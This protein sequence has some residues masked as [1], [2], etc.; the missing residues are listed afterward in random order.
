LKQYEF[1]IDSYQAEWVFRAIR[2][3]ADVIAVLM[4]SLKV[5]MLPATPVVG[6][7]GSITLRVS[8][9]SRIFFSSETKIFSIGFPF[10]VTEVDGALTFRTIHHSDVG[11]RV[12][13]Q[14]LGILESTD[15]L[16]TRE[17]LSFSEPISDICNADSDFWCLLRELLLTDYGYVRYDHD[18]ERQDGHLHPLHHIDVGYAGNATFKLGL[19]TASNVEHLADILNITTDCLYLSPP[20]G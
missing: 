5:M 7:I 13:S 17:I 12:T 20:A 11:S 14:I 8:K 1:S 16:D 18:A 4:N 19:K 3:K 9:M 15:A 6:E 2:C 10:S